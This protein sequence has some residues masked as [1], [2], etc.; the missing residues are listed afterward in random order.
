MG[1]SEAGYDA[2]IQWIQARI[3]LPGYASELWL[4]E[5]DEVAIEFLSNPG[6]QRLLAVMQDGAL[7]LATNNIAMLQGSFKQ[8]TYYIKP[9]GAKLS[10]PTIA[11]V[12]QYG[13][14]SG[15]GMHAL[16]RQ[17]NGVYAPQIFGSKA[18]PESIK[19]DF[20]G[21]FHKFMASLTETTFE[22]QGK[23]VLYLPSNS[24]DDVNVAA[25][26]KDLVQQLESVVIHWTRQIKEVVNNHD[27]ATDAEVHGPLEEIKFWRSRTV[28]LSGISEQLQRADVTKVVA[29]L[30]A[31]KSSC[32]ARGARRASESGR[33]RPRRRARSNPPLPAGPAR[34]LV[35]RRRPL[36]AHLPLCGAQLS[37]LR[38]SRSA[39]RRG[40]SRRTTTSS[41]SSR[42]RARARRS[43]RR[44]PRR[45]RRS[46]RGCSTASA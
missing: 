45:S 3:E 31:A 35:P 15:A 11:K 37:R 29:V 6:T 12:I 23:T 16:L 33:K 25:K 44:S 17:M 46:C 7:R 2:M 42:S 5:H 24:I 32:V 13:T 27:N 38:R 4:G 21:Q 19:K 14:I 8:L 39:S 43:P 34:C 9:D 22:A 10:R 41:S 40:A 20:T 18:W 36:P 30:D 28:D 1:E 26:N